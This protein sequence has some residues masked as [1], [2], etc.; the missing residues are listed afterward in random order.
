ML[1]TWIG[2]GANNDLSRLE[3]Y[4]DQLCEFEMNFVFSCVTEVPQ[5]QLLYDKMVEAFALKKMYEDVHDRWYRWRKSE[6]T[7]PRRKRN[8]RKRS[9]ESGWR[10]RRS[11]KKAE[12]RAGAAL[13]SGSFFGADRQHRLRGISRELFPE[14]A[15][16]YRGEG[17]LHC[18]H[19]GGQ[20]RDSDLV[21]I[22]AKKF[23]R[24]IDGG[25]TF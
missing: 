24:R 12:Q 20:T 25:F 1:L 18:H 22:V 3:K 7:R 17:A 16:G 10:S 6:G 21:Q 23:A 19:R 11:G 9:R 2:I 8:G 4:R 5:Y 13:H 14:S 15:G